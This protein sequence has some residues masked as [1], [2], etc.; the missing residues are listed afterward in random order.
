MSLKQQIKDD[1]KTAMKAKDKARLTTVRLMLAAIKQQEVDKQIE[2]NDSDVLVVL[3][4]MVKQRRDSIIQYNNAGRD[5]L[6]AVEQDEL[7]LIQ[8]YLPQPFSDQEVAALLDQVI[9]DTGASSKQDMGKVMAQLKAK[10]QGRADMSK[11]SGLVRAR[12]SE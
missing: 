11:V 9:T 12:L 8:T 2:L 1:M 4:K 3:N 10:L 5:E 6:A 7:S